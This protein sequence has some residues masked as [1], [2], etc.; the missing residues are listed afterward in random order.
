MSRKLAARSSHIC[1]CKIVFGPFFWLDPLCAIAGACLA[2]REPNVAV[3]SSTEVRTAWRKKAPK[4]QTLTGH[5]ALMRNMH[6]ILPISNTE[7]NYANSGISCS[8]YALQRLL[9]VTNICFHIKPLLAKNSNHTLKMQVLMYYA[10][11][12]TYAYAYCVCIT[13]IK[14]GVLSQK[15]VIQKKILS[16]LVCFVCLDGRLHEF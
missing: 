9:K 2:R 11:A 12:H 3:A 15:W 13:Y 7:Q 16:I 10:L 1:E 6:V 8:S 4:G 5:A 14:I